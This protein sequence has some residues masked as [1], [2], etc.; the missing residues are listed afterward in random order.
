MIEKARFC[1]FIEIHSVG[2][3]LTLAHVEAIIFR[4]KQPQVSSISIFPNARVSRHHYVFAEIA[5]LSSIV[6]VPSNDENSLSD[7]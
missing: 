3:A 6:I 7:F 2:A 4:E 1:H 5:E